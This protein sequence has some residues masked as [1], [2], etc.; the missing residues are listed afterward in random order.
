MPFGQLH[1]VP[2]ACLC[3][4]FLWQFSGLFFWGW[5]LGSC[6]QG[7]YFLARPAAHGI[8]HTAGNLARFAALGKLC[9]GQQQ[10]FFPWGAFCVFWRP[11]YHRDFAQQFVGQLVALF[12]TTYYKF[13]MFLGQFPAHCQ[14]AGAEN[15]CGLSKAFL[16]AILAL[17]K[18]ERPRYMGKSGKQGIAA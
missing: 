17:K 18:D 3:D 12:K 13:L 16:Q 5:L 1:S 10:H 14:F 4:S 8:L 9:I 6:Q 7:V 2:G 15:A 11:H